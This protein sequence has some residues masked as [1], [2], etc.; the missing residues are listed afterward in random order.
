MASSELR[1]EG[2]PLATTGIDAG[3]NSRNDSANMLPLPS[4]GGRRYHSRAT[5]PT[6]STFDLTSPR[7]R[8]IDPLAQTA[9][10]HTPIMAK[11]SRI[12]LPR[13]HPQESAPH[14]RKQNGPQEPKK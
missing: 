9:G 11:T 1:E 8:T 2:Y 10:T 4:S 12:G 7:P 14:P 13:R 3:S 5:S 6:T